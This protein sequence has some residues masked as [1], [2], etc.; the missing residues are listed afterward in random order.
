MINSLA[1]VRKQIPPAVIGGGVFAFDVAV[2]GTPVDWKPVPKQ[3]GIRL[4]DGGK[5]RWV[6]VQ[7]KT[8]IQNKEN[9]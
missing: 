9:L 7:R 4:Q 8:Y 2:K 5:G 6:R 3:I 1:N